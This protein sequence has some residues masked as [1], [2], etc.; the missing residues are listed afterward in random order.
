MPKVRLPR[1]AASRCYVTW[2]GFQ[3]L[4]T[5]SRVFLQLNRRPA[6]QS[7]A[8]GRTLIY[9]LPGCRVADFNNT[10]PLDTRFFDTPVARARVTRR[11]RRTTTLEVK[12]KQAAS[13]R[14]RIARLQGWYYLF[15]SF[16]HGTRPV[17]KAAGRRPAPR[18]P[19]A[20]KGPPPP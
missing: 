8:K 11:R 12:L 16:R 5:G 10:R 19:T 18:R 7:A 3:L 2:A 6:V 1:N 15:I 20:P 13:P 17:R 9:A 14:F 4:P